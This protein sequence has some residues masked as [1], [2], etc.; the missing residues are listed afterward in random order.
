[1]SVCSKGKAQ[2]APLKLV[3][4]KCPLCPNMYFKCRD[5]QKLHYLEFHNSYQEKTTNLAN[6][7]SSEQSNTKT[8]K[9]PKLSSQTFE[10]YEQQPQNENNHS[11]FRVTTERSNGHQ[12]PKCNMM[13]GRAYHLKRHLTQVKCE[14]SKKFS[15]YHCKIGF[16]YKS[17]YIRHL[18]NIHFYY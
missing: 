2:I 4:Y 13:F 5:T 11:K 12:C 9:M 8:I 7:S 3:I 16:D 10:F 1:M 15:C 18:R 17:T 6:N 14:R